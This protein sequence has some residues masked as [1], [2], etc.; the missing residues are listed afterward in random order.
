[1]SRFSL[2][3]LNIRLL[4]LVLLAMLP[5]FGLLLYNAAAER[6]RAA[7]VVQEDTRRLA[8]LTAAQIGQMVEGQRQLLVALASLGPVVAQD[9]AGCGQVL[10]GL[11]DQFPFYSSL[12]A[13]T[14][15]GDVFCSTV[16]VT[17][18]INVAERSWFQRAVASG[19]F[20]LGDYQKG[21][22]TG[23]DVV[24]GAYPA[25]DEAGEMRAVVSAALDL[26]RLNQVLA[27]AQLPAGAAVNVTDHTGTVLARYPDPAPWMGR[28]LDAGPLL[29][30]MLASSQGTFELE[31]VD[32]VAR[33]YAFEAVRVDAASPLHVAVGIPSEVAFAPAR[34]ALTRNLV[35]MGVAGVLALAV[36]RAAAEALVLR[37]AA[38]LHKATQRLTAGD[39]QARVGGPYGAGELDGLARSFDQMAAALEVRQGELQQAVRSLEMLSACNQA[40]VRADDEPALLS[41][42]CRSIVEIGGYRLAWIAVPDTPAEGPARLRVAAQAGDVPA[43]DGSRYLDGLDLTLGDSG[44]RQLPAVIT[45]RTGQVVTRVLRHADARGVPWLGRALARGYQAAIALPILDGGQ[46][47]GAL[48]LF[49]AE[50]NVFGEAG[51]G[52]LQELAD[53]VAFGLRALRTRAARA[54]AE[55]ALRRHAD[56]AET[57]ADV[58]RDLAAVATDEAG[59]LEVIARRVALRLGDVCIIR[60]LSDD[61]QWLNPVAVYHP[62]PAIDADVRQVLAAAP[63]PANQGAAKVVLGSGRAL[64][65]AVVT[66]EEARRL[67]AP[68]V[69][70][71]IE[72]LNL[73][74]VIFTPLRTQTHALGVLNVTRVGDSPAYTADDEAFAQDLADRAALSIVNAR[75]YRSLQQLNAELEA[76][77]AERTAALQRSASEFE[78]LYDQAPCG[79]HSLSDDGTFLRINQYELRL[80]GYARDEVVG[81]KRFSDLLTPDSLARFHENFPRFKAS[82]RVSNLEF[83]LVSRTGQVISVLLSASAVYDEAGRFVQSRSTL[84]DITERKQAEA[85]IQTLNDVLAERAQQLESANHELQAFSYSVS[86]DLRA[87]LR[88]IDGFSLALVEDYAD[89]LDEAA[90]DYLGRIRAAAQRMGELIDALLV[91]SRVTRAELRRAPLDLSSLAEA[92]A[93]DLRQREPER[94]VEAQI[95]PGMRAEGD[96]SLVRNVLENLL[97]NAWK[98][99]AGQAP[100][101]IEVGRLDGASE[102]LTFF[103]RDNGAGFDMAYA[104]RLF[105]AFQRLHD[106]REFKGTGIGLATVQRIIIRHGG[107]VWAEGQP[108]AGATFYFTLP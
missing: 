105:G 15:E 49:A 35:L 19:G 33:L 69:W 80:L 103:V 29:E 106:Q 31:G 68:P 100:A 84:I 45:L 22:I 47:L 4:L 46:P 76:R 90:R 5:A 104:D 88:S 108:G 13:A 32:G 11:I 81:Q 53:D 39:L 3:G 92:V 99:T 16:A 63:Q 59:V 98:F 75:L 17:G 38:S 97:G 34:A 30:Q 51:V 96:P 91:L 50:A 52:L 58:S 23:G 6:Q 40:L 25:G 86:H 55:A 94:P 107:R 9:A 26:A 60:L 8:R 48:S 85:Q 10:T 67:A 61:G 64:R 37:R 56:R 82:G 43:A 20:A 36:T 62:D 66:P 87:P 24:I 74:S 44:P 102:A 79:Y 54:Q 18:T 83:D 2:A 57:L 21:R 72:R 70:P 28:P 65:I 1:M 78:D 77:V 71:L 14:L 95:A 41:A 93:A 42:I 7:V 27:E 12:A 89:R 101:R 73:H